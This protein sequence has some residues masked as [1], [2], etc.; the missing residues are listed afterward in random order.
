MSRAAAPAPAVAPDRVAPR[1][2][3]AVVTDSACDLP[4]E[5]VIASSVTVVPLTVAFGEE[6]FLDGPE[7]SAHT[8]WQRMAA[9]PTVPTTASPSPAAFERAYA[10]ATADGA[11]GIV[12]IHLSGALSRTVDSARAAAERAPVPVDVVDSRSV[13]LGQGLVVLAAAGAA[14]VG[15]EH[16][17][18]GEKARSAVER[19]HVFAALET[20]DFLRRGGRVGRAKAALSE[21]LRVR[22]VLSLEDGEPTLVARPR[23][24]RRAID[25]VLARIAG[26]AEAAGV[27]HAGVPEAADLAA[28]VEARCGVV[29]LVSLIGAVTG[30]HLGP[31]AFG[32]AVL[33]PYP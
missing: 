19:L 25:E 1:S 4:P 9:S 31:G 23:T 18:V 11:E 3:V 29:P 30:S 13:S 10:A 24:R 12:S 17:A 8:F 26:S 16:T 33:R 7:L 22:P 5:E 2:P 15:A 21:L 20:V 6:A 14:A 28:A 27:L 32:V